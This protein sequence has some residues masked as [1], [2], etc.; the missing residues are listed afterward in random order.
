M[1]KGHG[2]SDVILF[3]IL[4]LLANKIGIIEDVVVGKSGCFR[5]AS[6]A[7]SELNV[8]WVVGTNLRREEAQVSSFRNVCIVNE[9]IDDVASRIKTNYPFQCRE[10]TRS[11]VEW[12]AMLHLG[13]NGLHYLEVIQVSKS[14]IHEKDTEPYLVDGIGKLIALVGRINVD[15]D[16][17]G[18]RSCH[19]HHDPLKFIVSIDANPVLRLQIELFNEASCKLSSSFIK[20]LVGESNVLRIRVQSHATRIALSFFS[21]KINGGDSNWLMVGIANDKTKFKLV[22]MLQRARFNKACNGPLKIFR[23]HQILFIHYHQ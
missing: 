14:I 13:Q 19:L 4:A 2:Y 7:R 11:Q 1:V 6:C 10:F 15:Q 18:H 3:R 8:G 5:P 9:A 23:K 20:L 17:I 21:E 12:V 16:E 22:E